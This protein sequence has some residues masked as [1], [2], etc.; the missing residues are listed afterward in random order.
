MWS[1]MLVLLR[2]IRGVFLSPGRTLG[3][4]M[5]ERRWVALFLLLVVL[6][7]LLNYITYP[8][9]RAK[10]AEQ[11][12]LTGYLSDDQVNSYLNTTM[13][14][15]IA[16]CAFSAVKLF[17][18]ISLGAMFLYLFFGIGGAE[19][20]YSNYFALTVNAS[21]IDLFFQELF[22]FLTMMFSHD[23]LLYTRPFTLLFNPVPKSFMSLFFI[24]IDIFSLWYIVA[25]ALGIS[26]F[27]TM[28]KKRALLIGFIYL[29]FKVTIQA[30]MGYIVVQVMARVT[31]N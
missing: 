31:G 12:L 29:L 11:A 23:Y 17:V 7:A 8:I 26:V 20:F 16:F 19:G 21:L 3:T 5:E 28:G 18:F 27:S 14:S 1:P 9:Q 15:R 22:I 2:D 24:R 30:A 6:F 4:L 13:F 10:M 25:V